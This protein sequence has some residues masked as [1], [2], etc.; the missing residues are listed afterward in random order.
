VTYTDPMEMP[1]EICRSQEDD[2]YFHEEDDRF[3]CPSC[4]TPPDGDDPVFP[5]PL[6]PAEPEDFQ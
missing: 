2:V 1:C 4:V 5:E 3:Y 6:E